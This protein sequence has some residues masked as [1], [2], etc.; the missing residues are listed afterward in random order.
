MKKLICAVLLGL[1]VI[2]PVL[3]GGFVSANDLSAEKLVSNK[4]IDGFVF[5]ATGEKGITI[6]TIDEVR[7]AEDG[8]IFN[9]RVKLNGSGNTSYRSVQFS[10][11]KGETLTVYLNSSSKSDARVL[12]VAKADGTVVQSLTAPPDTGEAGIA[13]CVL[14]DNGTYSIYSKS[15]GINLYQIIVE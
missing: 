3:A 10:A 4:D 7:E 13:N 11:K 8:E 6:E 15:S 9:A 2:V 12:I 5:K 14:P 1:G